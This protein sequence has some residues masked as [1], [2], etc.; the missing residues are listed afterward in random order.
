MIGSCKNTNLMSVDNRWKTAKKKKLC[1][2][3]LANN[4][5]GKDCR[6]AE[7]YDVKWLQEKSRQALLSIRR[8]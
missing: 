6:T 7:E 2:R 4:H 1:I 5:Q 8:K 3:F